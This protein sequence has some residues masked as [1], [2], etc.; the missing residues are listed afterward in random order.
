M[1]IFVLNPQGHHKVALKSN[2]QSGSS[3]ARHD[4]DIMLI[5]PQQA[6]PGPVRVKSEV[7]FL[8]SLIFNSF[9]Y[10]TCNYLTYITISIKVCCYQV[11][12]VKYSLT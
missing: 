10:S 2:N 5:N 11:W 12:K 1:L 3:Q 8:I 9:T 6:V 4:L 7:D